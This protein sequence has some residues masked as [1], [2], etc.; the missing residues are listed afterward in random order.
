VCWNITRRPPGNDE[1]SPGFAGEKACRHKDNK[2][3]KTKPVDFSTV[4][5]LMDHAVRD[6]VFP[7]A[8]LLVQKGRTPLYH[9]AFG[10]AN[11]FSKVPVSVDTVFDLASLTK[12]LATTLAVLL[13]VQDGK[14]VMNQPI[15][16]ILAAL[17][18]TEKE[19]IEVRHLLLHTSGLPAHRP[20]YKQLLSLPYEN[21]RE[22]LNGFLVAEPLIGRVGEKSV[23]SDIGFMLLRWV[24]ETMS[25]MGLDRFVAERVYQ[26]L[27]ISAIYFN[28]GNADNVKRAI[29]ATQWCPWRNSF[30]EGV[31]SDENAYASGGSDGHAGLFGTAEAVGGLI[32]E[33]MSTYLGEDN[34]QVFQMEWV[35][36]FL[37][38]D[39]ASGRA[40][41]FDVP[42]PGASSSGRFFSKETV[43]HLGYTGTSFWSDLK[44]GISVVLLTN[45]VHPSLENELIRDFRPKLHDAVMTLVAD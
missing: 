32:G 9:H 11:L 13:L 5:A 7:G 31:V 27:E 14:L 43:G 10:M 23:Y 36:R 30:L 38:R 8:V 34:R 16:T 21:R 6:R 25:G 3:N 19:R 33:L 26:P 22:R 24:V 12:P 29:A 35:R 42:T 15:G 37:K 2:E 17:K 44:T 18:G 41:G 20:Y 4:D 1:D 45:R 28:Q 39:E 40:F